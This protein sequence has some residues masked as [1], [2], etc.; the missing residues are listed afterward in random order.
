MVCAETC[1][2]IPYKTGGIFFLKTHVHGE[3]LI[4]SIAH[5]LHHPVGLFEN[6]DILN[7][8]SGQIFKQR[9]TVIVKKILAVDKQLIY[10]A[11]LHGY[12]AA[13]LEL[14]AG[15]LFDER[16]K[17]RAF[18]QF[19]SISVIDYCIAF[20]VELHTA[21]LDHGFA[22]LDILISLFLG[23]ANIPWSSYIN[24]IFMLIEFVNAPAVNCRLVALSFGFDNIF[25]RLGDCKDY[26]GALDIAGI[27]LRRGEGVYDGTVLGRHNR[28]F[29]PYHG[30]TC[31]IIY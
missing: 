1:I 22:Q 17:H 27:A 9:G 21:R 18:R 15:Q 11:P 2:H 7:H 23:L 25:T 31:H 8:I 16:V 3:Q 13:F 12:L 10:S 4:D 20:V 30:C 29:G 28:Y 19:E 5:H 14:H 6:L 24:V 26:E